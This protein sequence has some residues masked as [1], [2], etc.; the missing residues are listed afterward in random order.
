MYEHL[1][2]P[3]ILLAVLWPQ[4]RNFVEIK[5]IFDSEKQGTKLFSISTSKVAFPF[6]HCYW[7][8]VSL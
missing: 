5:S 1:Y 2:K 8:P 6:L 3:K 7:L 4:E